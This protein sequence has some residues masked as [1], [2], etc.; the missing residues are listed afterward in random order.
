M[1]E[2]WTRSRRGG[3]TDDVVAFHSRV[4]CLEDEGYIPPG[5]HWYY[6]GPGRWLGHYLQVDPWND[7][8]LERLGA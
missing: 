2:S 8:N 7:G 1:A 6:E 4:Y 3:P 5:I